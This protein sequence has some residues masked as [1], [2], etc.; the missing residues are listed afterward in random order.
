MR[1]IPL[2][3]NAVFD[4][5]A[6]RDGERIAIEVKGY[7]ET[8]YARGERRGQPKPTAPTLQARHWLSNALMTAM[9]LVGDGEARRVAIGLPDMPRYRSLLKSLAEAMEKLE[10]S[11][12][13]VDE[14]GGVVA[15]R[16]GDH[17]LQVELPVWR[18]SRGSRAPG[19]PFPF[20]CAAA[21]SPQLDRP[22][23]S[24]AGAP[25][26]EVPSVVAMA[27]RAQRGPG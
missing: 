1:Q 12:F 19:R 11:V 4:L 2:R 6:Q 18:G 9:L 13:L 3:A 26:R 8:T 25:Y 21:A 14:A 24:E 15:L 16:P 23:E 22:A 20:G 27:P 10:V 17:S 5:V 7:P